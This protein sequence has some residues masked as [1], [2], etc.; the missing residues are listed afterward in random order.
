[1]EGG[2]FEANHKI[3]ALSEPKMNEIIMLVKSPNEMRESFS[4]REGNVSEKIEKNKKIEFVKLA[5]LNVAISVAR[6]Y[7]NYIF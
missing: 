6:Y 1:M 7:P 2:F 5:W 3:E 4:F